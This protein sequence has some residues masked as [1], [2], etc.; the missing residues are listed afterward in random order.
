MKLQTNLFLFTN[1]RSFEKEVQLD[2]ISETK[3]R[4]LEYGEFRPILHGGKII[5]NA[6]AEILIKHV[7][8]QI[9]SITKIT[10]WRKSTNETWDNYSELKLKNHLDLVSFKNA[11]SDGLKIY[12]LFYDS[13]YISSDLKDK[14]ISEYQSVNSINFINKWPTHA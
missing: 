5:E 9:S 8:E 7:P 14:I 6:I 4:I 2:K 1:K 13:L 10:I 12:Q 11:N 3:Y